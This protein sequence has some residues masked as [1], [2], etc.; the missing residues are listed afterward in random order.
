M[1]KPIIGVMG[2]G[3]NVSPFILDR[4]YELGKRIA[5]VGWILLTGGRDSGVMR[6]ASEGAKTAGGLTIGILPGMNPYEASP[7]VDIPICTGLGHGRNNVNVLSSQVVIACGSGTGTTSEIALALKNNRPVI[8]LGMDKLS[9]DFFQ[10]LSSN[11]V[12]MTQSAEETIEIVK[13]IL[14]G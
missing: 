3:K 4:A 9:Q 12:Y 14:T 1:P 2:P 10:Q 6:A 5:Q 8:L 11:Q 7:F 13:Q